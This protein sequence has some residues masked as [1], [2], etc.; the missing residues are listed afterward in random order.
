MRAF[1]KQKALQ[2][3]LD[4]EAKAKQLEDER[5]EAALLVAHTEFGE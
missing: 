5:K 3:K 2:M 1:L 4:A